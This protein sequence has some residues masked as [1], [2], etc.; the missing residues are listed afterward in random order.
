LQFNEKDILTDLGMISAEI[1]KTV[2]ENEFEKYSVKQN[3]I[4]ESDFDKEIKL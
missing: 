2:A 1:A 4:F 3:Q